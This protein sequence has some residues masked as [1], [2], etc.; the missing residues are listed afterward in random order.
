ML[1]DVEPVTDDE[2]IFDL[3]TDIVHW[4]TDNSPRRFVKKSADLDGLG[5]TR[6]QQVQKRVHGAAGVNNVLHNDDIPTFNPGIQIKSDFDLA[7]RMN[8]S[9]ITGKNHEIPLDVEVYGPDQ[10][11]KEQQATL[12]DTDNEWCLTRVSEI[13]SDLI[14]QFPDSG[15]NLLFRKKNSFNVRRKNKRRSIWALHD[16]PPLWKTWKYLAWIILYKVDDMWLFVNI[17]K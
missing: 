9:V 1:I 11:R 6:P 15:L 5:M 8:T 7:S 2:R 13:T 3:E 14:T 4:Y 12:H 16:R 17:L 10:I